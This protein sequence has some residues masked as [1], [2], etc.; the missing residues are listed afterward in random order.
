MRINQKIVGWIIG[1]LLLVVL[2]VF[3]G[4]YFWPGNRNRNAQVMAWLR[5]AEKYPEWSVQA[6]E[7]CGQAPF[8]LPTSGFI[9]FIWGDSFWVGHRHQ[10]IDIFGGGP[11]NETAVIAAYSGYLTRQADWK[12]TIVIRIPDDPLQP[13]RQIWT[14]Y[15]HMAGPDGESTISAEFPPGTTE[16][17][18][19]AGAFLGY[20]GNYSGNAGRPVGVHLHFS[21]VLD[22]GK[23]SIRNEL[24]MENTLDP[25]PYLGLPLNAVSNPNRIPVCNNEE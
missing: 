5:N 2:V 12:S 21:I 9:G 22:D 1:V 13:G 24:E 20:Q 17:Y 19:P 10:G 8:I 23:G 14:Y 18:V 25:S 11:V 3:V 6:G 16:V 7:R 15:T 4:R